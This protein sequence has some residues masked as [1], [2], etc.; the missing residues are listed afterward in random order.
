MTMQVWSI[1]LK[2]FDPS[3][4]NLNGNETLSII[5]WSENSIATSYFYTVD[6]FIQ[7]KQYIFME[8]IAFYQD[9]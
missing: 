9:L 3:F 6:G 8:Y 2:R 5:C 1:V 7:I 4:I